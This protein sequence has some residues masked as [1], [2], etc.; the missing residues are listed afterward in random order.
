MRGVVTAGSGETPDGS[1]AFYMQEGTGLYSGINVYISSESGFSVSRGDSI[2]VSGETYEYYG[3]PEIINVSS[4]AV[5]DDIN[6]SNPKASTTSSR[7]KKSSSKRVEDE[8][9]SKSGKV[10]KKKNTKGKKSSYH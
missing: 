3:K 9:S 5:L 1:V 2:E 6:A 7:Q 4:I 8:G 10:K